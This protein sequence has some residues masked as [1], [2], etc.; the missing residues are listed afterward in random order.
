MFR[1]GQKVVC[2]DDTNTGLV[3][4]DAIYTVRNV[5]GRF[6]DLVGIFAMSG[7]MDGMLASR[8][9]PAV[10]RKTDITIFTAM[11]NPAKKKRRADRP[12][13]VS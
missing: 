5:R 8:F 3:V 1:V 10:E 12:V 4:R 13:T 9:R 7:G 2:V 6:L 11:L